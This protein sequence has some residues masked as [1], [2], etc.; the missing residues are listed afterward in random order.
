[1]IMEETMLN[2]IICQNVIE[3]GKFNMQLQTGDIVTFYSQ[4]G[5]Q[6]HHVFTRI[7]DMT[8]KLDQE[9][10]FI[11]TLIDFLNDTKLRFVIM[12]DMQHGQFP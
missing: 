12:P 11:M 9:K 2:N 3:N 8:C 6:E 5:S 1:M 10:Y 7:D 4:N